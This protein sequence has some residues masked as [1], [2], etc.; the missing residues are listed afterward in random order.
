MKKHNINM[1]STYSILKASIVERLNRT[2]KTSIFKNFTINGNQ[3]WTRDL[4]NLVAKYNDTI[5]STIGMKPNRVTIADEKRLLNTVYLETKSVG[6]SKFKIG[7]KV[8]IS[9][10]KNLFEKG[11]TPNWTTEIFTIEKK[12]LTNPVTYLLVD[13]QG[14]SIKGGFYEHEL[15]KTKHPDVFLVE[16]VLRRKGNK[17]FV[18][19]L[20]FDV[21][22]HNSWIDK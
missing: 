19:W 15:Q 9:K 17:E 10:Y 22:N 16:K 5:H 18:K 11:Y 20:G 13:S 3:N 2:I 14:N 7:E 1:Y 8:R 12:Q 21:N 6:R 4:Q